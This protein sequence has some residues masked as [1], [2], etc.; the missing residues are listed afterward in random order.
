M[1]VTA[2]DIA[3]LLARPPP[4]QVPAHVTKAVKGGRSVWFLV[5]FGVFFGTFGMLFVWLFFPWRLWDE[6]LLSRDGVREASGLVNHVRKTNMSVNEAKVYEYRFSFVPQAGTAVSALCFAT[7]R[8]WIE[9]SEVTVRYLPDRPQVALIVGASLNQ[10]G[11]F[12][13]FVIIF[14]LVGYGMAGI[15]LIFRGNPT[16]LLREGVAAEIDVL[17]VEKTTMTVNDQPV[18]R[19]TLSAPGET[20]GPPVILRRLDVADVNLA[21]QHAQ[22]KQPVFVL[23]D[24][25]KPARMIFPEAL[26]EP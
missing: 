13:A 23:Y 8:D 24:P 4:R 16:R 1:K 19:I 9:G 3:Q 11:L 5:V 21:T 12:G 6:W 25:R 10:G 18:Y 14:P 7:G 22:Q 15:A 26:I 20:G 17:S 2:D